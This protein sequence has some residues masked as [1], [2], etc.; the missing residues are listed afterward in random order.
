MSSGSLN[1]SAAYDSACSDEVC[2]SLNDE[3]F[4]LMFLC[5]SFGWIKY[6]M[7]DAIFHLAGS[8][9]IAGDPNLYS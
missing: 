7:P 9:F 6:A 8:T 3:I 4:A 2:S 5:F 1:I